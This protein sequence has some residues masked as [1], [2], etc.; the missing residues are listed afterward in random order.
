MRSF[1]KEY[2]WLLVLILITLITSCVGVI[3]ALLW[4][5]E[6]STKAVILVFSLLSAM[7]SGVLIGIPMQPPED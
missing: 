4:I 7:L 1:L 3:G 2:G 5:E 6:L